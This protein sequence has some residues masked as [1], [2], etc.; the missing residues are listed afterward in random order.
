MNRI[1]LIGNGFDKAHNLQTGYEDFINW[2][3]DEWEKRL[4]SCDG[5]MAQDE[6][7]SYRLTSRDCM[8]G[9]TNIMFEKLPAYDESKR[10]LLNWANTNEYKCRKENKSRLFK[11]I[12]ETW[13]SCKNWFDIEEIY[14]QLLNKET[15]EIKKIND[16]LD[17]IKQKLCEYLSIIEKQ[18]SPSIINKSI[19]H[20]LYEPIKKNDISVGSKDA[21]NTEISNR[22]Q[23]KDEDW[24]ELVSTYK[25]DSDSVTRI[26]ADIKSFISSCHS[27]DENY[28]N[29][30]QA[31]EYFFLPNHTLLL[32][33]NYTSTINLYLLKSDNVIL[34]QIHGKLS[35]PDSMI[36][37]YGDELDDN[38][39]SLQ[40][41]KD[42]EFLRHIKSIKYLEAPNYRNI[43]SFIESDT[44]QVYIMGHS[45]GNSDRTL[46]N[47]LF[48]HK[49]CVSIKPF[50]YIKKDGSNNFL[51]LVQNISRSFTDMSLM[52]DRVVNKTFC[53]TFT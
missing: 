36:F 10:M 24:Y 31:P 40:N 25:D 6:F 28:F 46:L 8:S 16:D 44:Y 22:I 17:L 29:Y 2:Y 1:I 18:I 53:E 41:K 48:E 35:D 47:K 19:S 5:I 52:R 7:L 50:Y 26:C 51:D 30:Q 38:Y 14:Y 33:F 3:W 13:K 12:C 11:E 39:K 9:W 23:Y 15:L 45:C 49:N 4:F 42:N 20:K 27:I 21:W 43:L 34:D 32:D 37:G